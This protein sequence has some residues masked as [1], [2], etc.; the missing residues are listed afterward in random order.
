MAGEK[1]V[2]EWDDKDPNEVLD[3]IHDWS[4]RLRDGDAVTAVDAMV[5]SVDAGDITL[6]VDMT[7][8]TST[9]QTVKVS[10]GI[11]G[12]KY[13]LTLRALIDGGPPSGQSMDT[14]IILKIKE[15]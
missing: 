12:Q 11:A 8:F 2:F 7:S 15:W 9:F 10:G 4:P 6:E 1:Q 14:G 5:D 13:H 3:Y